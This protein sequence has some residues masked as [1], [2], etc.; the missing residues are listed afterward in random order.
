MTMPQNPPPN[1][2][3]EPPPPP[4][5][6]PDAGQPEEGAPYGF[7][8]PPG[9]GP[10][11]YGGYSQPP[12]P[13]VPG[14][15]Q[16]AQ[17]QGPVGQIRPTGM[18]MLLFFVTLGIWSFVYYFQTH[19][20]MKR[21]TGEGVGGVIALVIAIIF[22]LINPFL[23]SHEVGQLYSRRGAEPPVTALTA[24]WFFPG[25]FILVGPFIWFIQTNRALNEY[26]QSLGQTR[27]TLV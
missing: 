7:A 9:Y 26:W 6:P 25:I 11:A 12:M 13:G 20:E 10:P 14:Y 23:L 18:I 5:P 8:P 24:L 21:H 22:G 17:P 4:P 2:Q 16:Y 15:A 3:Q 1:P 19:E 27:T